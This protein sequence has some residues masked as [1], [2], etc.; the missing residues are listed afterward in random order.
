ME[1][2]DYDVFLIQEGTRTVQGRRTGGNIRFIRVT[3]SQILVSIVILCV[4]GYAGDPETARSSVYDRGMVDLKEPFAPLGNPALLAMR[5]NLRIHAGMSQTA[6]RPLLVSFSYPLSISTG[7]GIAW[8]SSSLRKDVEAAGGLY[9]LEQKNQSILFNVGHQHPFIIG[10]QLEMHYSLRRYNPLRLGETDDAVRF[11]EQRV[12]F[13]YRLGWFHSLND[14]CHIGVMTCPVVYLTS[15]THIDSDLPSETEWTF[16]NERGIDTVWPLVACEWQPTG[17][18]RLALSNRSRNHA[19]NIQMA[20]DYRT[21]KWTFAGS[22]SRHPEYGTADFQ[23]GIG[24]YLKGLD[25]FTSY[26]VRDRVCRVDMAFSPE[27]FEQMINLVSLTLAE[28]FFY[29]YHIENGK[30]N[31]LARMVLDNITSDPV[32]LSIIMTGAKLPTITLT[33]SIQTTGQEIFDIPMPV[34]LS[35]WQP[36]QYQYSMEIKAYRRKKQVVQTQLAFEIKDRHDW[37]GNPD[38]LVYFVQP[39]EAMIVRQTRAMIS[40][41]K[42]R[43]ERMDPVSVASVFYEYI[44]DSIQYVPDPRPLHHRQDHSQ[45]AVEVLSSGT[46]DCE[47]IAVLMVSFLQSVGVAASFI[48][49]HVPETE[50]GHVFVLMDTQLAPSD[51]LG[52]GENLQNYIVRYTDTRESRCY[53]PLELTEKDRDFHDSWHSALSLYHRYGIEK[54]GLVQGWFKIVDAM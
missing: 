49:Y 19:D 5:N 35:Q 3:Y 4:S 26:S 48:V 24:G 16:W 46:G 11:N 23:M 15:R 54:G 14:R 52:R 51:V 50:M 13:I 43:G 44:R 30:S 28:P 32:D 17:Q 39:G 37:S 25:F 8:I 41:M 10:H 42:K 12:E 9:D 18:L 31:V 47:D 38:D 20:V 1:Y 21:R 29:P 53:I 45:Y 33:Q 22:V 34:Q 36:G 6:G 7:L 2:P 27:R 40:D